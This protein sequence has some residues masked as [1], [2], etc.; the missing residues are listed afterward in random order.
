MTQDRLLQMV[1][2][3]L[4]MS[5]FRVSER[6]SMRPRSFDLIA[7]DRNTILVIKVVSHIDSISEEIAHDLD[8]ISRYLKASPLIIGERARDAELERG[9]VYVRYGIYAINVSTLYDAL[10][11]SIPPLV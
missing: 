5:G 4:L 6:F 9:A 3:V 11:E 8:H 10:V 1:I 2:S 7:S